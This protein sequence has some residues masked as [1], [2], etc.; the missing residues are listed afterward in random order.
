MKPIQHVLEAMQFIDGLYSEH[1]GIAYFDNEES[2]NQN[3]PEQITKAIKK[4]VLR[5]AYRF[6][7]DYNFNVEEIAAVLFESIGWELKF[8][9][10]DQVFD[11]PGY[12]AYVMSYVV[13]N[14]ETGEQKFSFHNLYERD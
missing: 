5:P 8:Y 6:E 1:G 14:K 10:Y 11:S 2:I 7:G 12:D 13:E 4:K 3:L 9:V